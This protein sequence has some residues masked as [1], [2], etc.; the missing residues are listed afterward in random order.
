MNYYN[1][2]AQLVS[3][4][5]LMHMLS[6]VQNFWRLQAILHCVGGWQVF[7]PSAS[8]LHTFRPGIEEQSRLI[9]QITR[10]K[11]SAN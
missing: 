11:N 5:G 7:A 4:P 3:V 10:G 9:P 6:S 2:S 1:E 8:S